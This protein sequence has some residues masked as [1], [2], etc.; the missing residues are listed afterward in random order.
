ML[1]DQREVFGAVLR[2]MG[3][4]MNTKDPALI[5]AAKT[6]LLVQKSLVKAYASEHYDQLLASGDVVLAHGWGG[7]I[8]RAM[9]DRPS[10]RYIVPKEAVE[11]V[12]PRRGNA[13]FRA[14]HDRALEAE[15]S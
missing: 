6:R 8:A 11:S 12:Q 7:P 15:C 13:L 10:I 1:N 4:S 9:L 3:A 5:E 2:L 14:R